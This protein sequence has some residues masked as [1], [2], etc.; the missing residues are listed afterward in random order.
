VQWDARFRRIRKIVAIQVLGFGIRDRWKTSRYR[1]QQDPLEKV[2]I[3]GAAA[4][5][6]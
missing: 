1:Y 4:K 3:G 6:G 5:E 2:R